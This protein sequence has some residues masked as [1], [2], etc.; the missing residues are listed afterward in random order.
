LKC[1]T[2]FGEAEAAPWF[3]TRL[4]PSLILWIRSMM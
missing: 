1:F 4:W 3:S 2:F